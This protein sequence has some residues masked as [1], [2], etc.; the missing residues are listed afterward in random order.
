MPKFIPASEPW[1]D[2]AELEM[3]QE[4]IA[5]TF[6]SEHEMTRR[7]EAEL[8][9]LTGAKHAIAV[10]NG[11]QAL[12]C[13]LKTLGLKPGSEVIVPA[14]TCIATSN[15]VLMAGGTPVLVDV[16]RETFCIDPEKIEAAITPLTRGICPVHLYG[17][18]AKMDAI[19]EIARRHSLWVLEDAAEGVGVR[20]KD[21]HVGT[22]AEIGVLSFFGNKTITT[23]EGGAVLTN[24]D[25][26]AT[27]CRRFKNY[28]RDRRGELVHAE[29]G[30]NFNFTDLQA[31]VGLSQLKKLPEII[32]R[33]H[34]VRQKYEAA[35]ADV[36]GLWFTA[37]PDHVD[38]VFWFTSILVD[39]PGG[40]AK[41]LA[42]V[43]IGTRRFF[44]PLNQQPCYQGLAWGKG[45]HPASEWAYQHALS[46][47]SSAV[48]NVVDQKR[49]IDVVRK[50]FQAA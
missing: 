24:V 48:L 41:H 2:G 6:V 15:A 47:P 35:L 1:I 33:K 21:K 29:I 40:L 10:P 32:A 27:A 20:Y 4:V 8:C 46:L 44:Y 50:F 26:L 25:V 31:A 28:G 43:E 19:L 17:L 5:S 12:Y 30:F 37:V 39:D 42:D 7:F 36:P 38:P 14:L 18:S 3:L 9:A 34:M 45:K 16:D 13:G 23:G 11:T 22:F 49:V